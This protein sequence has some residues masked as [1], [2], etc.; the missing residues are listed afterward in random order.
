VQEPFP[1]TGPASGGS[2]RGTGAPSRSTGTQ[3]AVG[4]ILIVLALGLA[5]RLIV[6][7][8]LPGSGFEVDLNAFRFWASNLAS[9][10]LHGFYSRDFF[11]DYTPGYLYILWLV[12]VIGGLVGGVGDLIKIPPIFAD[13]AIGYLVWSMIRELGARDRLAL[14]GGAAAVLN[15]ISWFDSVAWGQVDS[16]GVV[17]LLLALRSLWRD[18]PERS[19]LF[20]V[21][22]AVIKPQLGI[23]IPLVAVVTIRRAL[24]PTPVLVAP[25]DRPGDDAGPRRS[26][27]G[28][29]RAWERRTDSAARIVTTGVA[30]LLTAV[31]LCFPFGLSVIDLSSQPP[32]IHS[33]LVD[34]IVVAGGGYPYLTVNAYNP[35]AIV[36]GDT[37]NSL[38]SA[39]LWICDTA[40]VPGDQCTA[41]T[42]LIAG[43][44][45]VL[46][47]GGLLIVAIGLVLWTAARNP[48]RLTLLVALAV[49]A[50]AFFVLPTRVHERYGYPFFALGAIL[51]AISARWR[52][53]YVV[54]TI[55]TFANMYVVLTT[56]YDNPSID[57]WLGVGSLL[58]SQAGVTAVAIAHAAA[59]VWVFV[60][61]RRGARERLEEQLERAGAPASVRAGAETPPDRDPAH[62]RWTWPERAAEG[63]EGPGARPLASLVAGA[64][65]AGS[66]TTVAL[67][68][69]SPPR[70]FTELGF[71]G[72]LRERLG[73]R[74]VRADRSAEL[75]REGGGRLDRLDLWML[76]VLVA[77]TLCLR[78]FRLAEPYQMH[79]DEVYHARTA[80][81]F[82]QSWRYGLSHDIYEWTHPHLAKYIM[83]GGIVLWGQDAVSA[84]SQVGAPVRAAVIEPRRDDPATSKRAGERVHVATGEEIRSYDLRTRQLVSTV[85]A[86]GASALAIDSTAEQL[87]VGFE[88][89]R[90]ETLDLATLGAEGVEPVPVVKVAH[91]VTHLLVTPDGATILAASD[92]AVSAVDT[93][94]GEVAGTT[95]L[96]AIADLANAGTGAAIVT[97]PSAIQDAT[98]MATKL[99]ALIGGA[100][101]DYEARLVGVSPDVQ[102]VL[103]APG[104]SKTRTAV[105]GAIADGS[106]SGVEVVDLPRV[107]VADGSGVTFVDPATAAV[108]ST[109]PIDGG[110]H[111]LALVTSIEDTKVYATTG[112]AAAPGYEV[113]AV[114]GDSAK[115]GPAS[116][117]QHPLPG[118]GTRIAYD[119]ATQQVHVLGRVPAADAERGHDGWTV[120][121][122]EPH[123][124]AVYADAKLPATMTPAAWAMDVES[125]YMTDDREALL[126]FG[127][128]GATASIPLGSHAFAW[129]LPGVIAGALTAGLLYLL[130]R[131]LF[132]RRL[133]AGLVGAFVLLDGMLFVQS[134]IGMND[135]YVGL[136]I[137]AAYTLF[138]AVWTGWWRSRVAFWLSMPVIGLLLGLALASKWVAAYAIGALALL[139]L[140]RSALG[141]VLAILGLIAITS[142]LGYLALAV[143]EGQGPGNLTFLFIMIGL[144]VT[145]VVAAVLHPIAWSDDEVR[146]ALLGPAALG[147]VVFFGALAVGRLDTTVTLSKLTFTPLHVALAFVLAS[148]VVAGLFRLAG[149]LGF[150]PFAGVPGP[151]DPARLLEPPAPAPDGW[152]RPG[153]LA[154]IPVLV[155]AICLVAIPLAVYVISYIPWALI[156][157]HQ[158]WAGVPAGHTGQTLIE[159]TGQM[160]GYHNGLTSP[161]P[162][163]SP[164]WAWPFD[165]KPVWFYQDGFAAGTTAAIYDAGNLVIWWLGVPALIFA[166]VMAF[167]RRSLPL[168]LIAIGFAGQWIP[169]SR[170]ERAAFQYHYYTAL[171]FLILALAYLVAE[172]WHGPSRRTWLAARLV[173]AAAI[174][175]P[176]ALWLLSRPLC[177]FVG[178]TTVNPGS[179]ACPATIPDLT[180]TVR[181][182]A[183]LGV[184][185]VGAFVLARL[186]V[187]LGRRSELDAPEDP[188]TTDVLLRLL[189]AA[190]VVAVGFVGARFLPDAS[191]FKLTSVPVEPIALI[192]AL[193]LGYFA[194]TAIAARDARRFAVGM[195]LAAAA[196]FVVWYPNIA[197]LPLPA[198]VVNAYQGLLPT[199]LYAFQ[200]PVS[201]VARNVDTPLLSPTLAILAAAVTVTC[202]VV[203][204]SAWAWRV[205]LA[206]SAAASTGVGA[207]GDPDGLARGGGD[208]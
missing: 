47:G 16:F 77:A 30:G 198:A 91:P 20:T 8:L 66:L 31:V 189:V 28:R 39:G 194:S 199:Y 148:L 25:A 130:A 155:A 116:L 174:V 95:D 142:V 162:A 33:G 200:F 98:A 177:A 48:D 96:Q 102:V 69:W 56:L 149:G 152:L 133:V 187:A 21:I 110:A 97:T 151:A 108:S 207:S 36:P 40:G 107:A 165:L 79:F 147:I 67:P 125:Q 173:A 71:I 19:A 44:P 104:D 119:D 85:P 185:A 101:A 59:F 58:R 70:T 37:G 73:E 117:G 100:P 140:V 60:Q 89:G 195:T 94:T 53:A 68:T 12:G 112:T 76:V 52:V 134:R 49:L 87:V 63:I 109:I 51:F 192:V 9:Q 17:F 193:P 26:F 24:W 88:D 32:F 143:P 106:L 65:T 124:N 82:L 113:I 92:A 118:L 1:V 132:R 34:Q 172:L 156:E 3:G 43:I 2:E 203:A 139:L 78:T 150:G 7:Y 182:I 114:A 205:S 202:L 55:A 164:W 184:V 179:Q 181:S 201:T 171:P 45:A 5:L 167:R 115:N 197:A 178:V 206:A 64:G 158:L 176:A 83:A 35:W 41:G 80:A 46:V 145:G 103:G 141:R 188:A 166:S 84:S 72:W 138:A 196:W 93:A 122:I 61:L 50:L 169:W 99:A 10:G 13:L 121:V 128:D 22:A 15:P 161:H 90:I 127:S 186:I 190:V 62:D 81:E 4:A 38:A 23:L 153:W 11:H 120:Y 204:Y 175:A 18:Q 74:P 144:T 154:G 137:V 27:A 157:N 126:V 6:A 170:I 146:A 136:F 208:A 75:R 57:D 191:L 163:S 135:V 14:V 129:R 29:L 42:A 86:P 111:G 160:Y 183:L 159:L 105:E 168:A 131:I 180:L 123:G 54:L